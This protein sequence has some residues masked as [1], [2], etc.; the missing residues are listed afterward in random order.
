MAKKIMSPE[1]A[2]IKLAMSA[3]RNERDGLEEKNN[4]LFRIYCDMEGMLGQKVHGGYGDMHYR[5]YYFQYPSRE[6]EHRESEMRENYLKDNGYY[7]NKER[8]EEIDK[9]LR[10]LESSLCYAQYGMTLQE[11]KLRDTIAYRQRRINALLEEIEKEKEREAE[12]IEKLNDYL[13]DKEA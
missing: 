5:G 12:A 11:K 8:M 7:D 6:I 1:V 10:Q 2:N 4:E 9:E 3:R 13:A